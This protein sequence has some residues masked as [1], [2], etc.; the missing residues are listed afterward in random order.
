MY[1]VMWIILYQTLREVGVR[2][3]NEIKRSGNGHQLTECAVTEE[4][5]KDEALNAASRIAGLVRSP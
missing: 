4:Q 3:A 2:E 5:V 1:H